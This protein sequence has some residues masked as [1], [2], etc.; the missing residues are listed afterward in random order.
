M[1]NWFMAV[2][3][4][5]GFVVT[6]LTTLLTVTWKMGRSSGLY[7][8]KEDLDD[9]STRRDAE[10]EDVRKDIEDLR[11]HELAALR[12]DT[13]ETCA[14]IRQKVTET[15][16][17]N[18]DNFVRLGDFRMLQSELDARFAV[19]TAIQ[20][21]IDTIW[22]FQMRRAMSEV[23]EAGVGTK[24]SPLQF[25]D[26]A[27]AAMA[28]IADELEL[29]YKHMPVDV[30]LDDSQALLEIERRFGERLL[31]MV[32]IPCKLSH[33]ACLIL[34]YAVAKGTDKLELHLP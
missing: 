2:I 29:F 5:C 23:V 15:E 33:G 22:S 31:D 3:A 17:W 20:V 25:T 1:P 34:A 18:R 30:K 32:C 4:L 6:V 19:L 7:V 8:T 24:N 11:R 14:A 21:K 28:P 27:R 26:E 10:L 12:N 9:L 16:L 13:G